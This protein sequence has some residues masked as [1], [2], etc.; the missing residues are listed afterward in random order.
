MENVFKN[1]NTVVTFSVSAPMFSIPWFTKI[2]SGVKDTEVSLSS[3]FK[4][5]ISLTLTVL[6]GEIDRWGDK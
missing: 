2:R 4:Y 3:L 6:V 1:V 5:S